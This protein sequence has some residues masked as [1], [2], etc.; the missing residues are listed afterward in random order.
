LLDAD[1]ARIGSDTGLTIAFLQ[2]TGKVCALQGDVDGTAD[3]AAR[4]CGIVEHF[5]DAPVLIEGLAET[6]IAALT[7]GE[8]AAARRCFQR[9]IDTCVALELRAA[10]GDVLVESALERVLSGAF[11]EA[12]A[13][14]VQGLAM[15]GEGR[16]GRDRAVVAALAVAAAID[17]SDLLRYEPDTGFIERVFAVNVPLV[18]GPLAA[19]HAQILTRRGD[20]DAAQR[21]LRRAVHA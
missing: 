5:D 13:L 19:Y 9:A 8:T 7:I 20:R 3:A 2:L 15:I 1:T 6:G 11:E 10:H 14:V 12:R 21:L 16:L 17:D 18:F 4:M